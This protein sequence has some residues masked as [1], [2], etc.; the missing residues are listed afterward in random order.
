MFHCPKCHFAIHARTSCYFTDT[1]KERYLQCIN[2]NCSNI[3][4]Y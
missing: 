3:C 1:A 4:H 2:I